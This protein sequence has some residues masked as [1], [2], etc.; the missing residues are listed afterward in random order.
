MWTTLGTVTGVGKRYTHRG[1]GGRPRRVH[2][3][4]VW[5]CEADVDAPRFPYRRVGRLGDKISPRS[6][7][8]FVSQA[9]SFRAVPLRISP[10]SWARALLKPL[11]QSIHCSTYKG[12]RNCKAH[13][14]L[15]QSTQAK[16]KPFLT[17]DAERVQRLS[18][19]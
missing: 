19:I 6:G 11:P 15:S 2:P 17:K 13:Q 10:V 9:T 8:F 16:V 12:I 5:P 4:D 1:Y 7:F 3:P 14:R 18:N